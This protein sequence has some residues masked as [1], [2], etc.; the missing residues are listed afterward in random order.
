MLELTKNSKIQGIFKD[1]L[2]ISLKFSNS[3]LMRIPAYNVREGERQYM[4]IE[5]EVYKITD[6][7][8]T[9]K[10]GINE[11]EITLW[12]LIWIQTVCKG[13]QQTTLADTCTYITNI[14]CVC[15]SV[16]YMCTVKAPNIAHLSRFT[17][18][19]YN[20]KETKLKKCAQPN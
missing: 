8:Q 18:I 4:E 5:Y 2:A 1:H 7:K 14:L 16:L 10:N 9:L 17:S 11:F 13:Y 3:S 6:L 20:K 15:M 19:G 12:G